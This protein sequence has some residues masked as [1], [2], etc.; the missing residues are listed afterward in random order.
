MCRL[1]GYCADRLRVGQRKSEVLRDMEVK[2]KTKIVLAAGCFG[3]IL[4]CLFVVFLVGPARMNPAEG[5]AD[6]DRQLGQEL[7]DAYSKLGRAEQRDMIRQLSSEKM[8]SFIVVVAE[9]GG[10][11]LNAQEDQIP[12]DKA[13]NMMALGLGDWY[14]KWGEKRVLVPTPTSDERSAATAP[15]NGAEP[16]RTQDPADNDR[17]RRSEDGK[18]T[19]RSHRNSE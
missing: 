1:G 3:L 11:E 13:V 8:F 5:Q 16:E 7:Y 9:A 6:F 4:L 18:Q 10:V 12:H 17:D 14:E 2:R 15:G 19:V